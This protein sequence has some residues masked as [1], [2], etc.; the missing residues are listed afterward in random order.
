MKTSILKSALGLLVILVCSAQKMSTSEN[1]TALNSTDLIN[2]D[3][4]ASTIATENNTGQVYS[5]FDVVYHNTGSSFKLEKKD[6]VS[7]VLNLLL[8]F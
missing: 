6:I 8:T 5:A 7:S 4:L 1:N 2:V 3:H